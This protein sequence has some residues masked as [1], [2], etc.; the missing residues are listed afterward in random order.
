MN[1]LQWLGASALAVLFL[2][3]AAQAQTLTLDIQ[4]GTLETFISNFTGAA[5]PIDGYQIASPIGILDPVDWNSI[6]DSAVSNPA[7]VSA[8]LG[9]GAL[10]FIEAAP[11][12]N[13]LSELD[14]VS[15]GTWQHT[16][17]WSIGY[18]FG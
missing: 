16:T 9:S 1:R 11:T 4:L 17:R 2:G 8:T 6:A 13:S 7:S 5:V 14:V 10:S 3:P 18:P 12:V 15:S